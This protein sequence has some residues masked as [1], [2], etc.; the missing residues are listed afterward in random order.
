MHRTITVG[1]LSVC[2]AVFLCPAVGKPDVMLW[3]VAKPALVFASQHQS[4]GVETKGCSKLSQR[5]GGYC[6]QPQSERSQSSSHCCPATC[7]A[8]VLM[9][10]VRQEP[11]IAQFDT[12]TNLA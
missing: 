7:S 4:C 3:E 9:C 6:R 8:L 2:L 11:R 5:H 10:T 12:N 1:L